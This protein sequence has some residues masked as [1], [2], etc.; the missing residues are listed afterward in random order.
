MADYTRMNAKVRRA[1]PERDA[2]AI[3]RLYMQLKK[4]HAALAPD[5]P[6]YAVEDETWERYARK[7]LEEEEPRFYVAVRSGEVV[8]FLKLFFEEKSW[9]LACEVETLVVDERVRGT[10]VGDAL[11]RRAEEVAR[12]EG[13][14]GMRVNV[15]HLNEEGRRFY[16]RDG[17]RAVAIRYG[18]SL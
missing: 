3:A 10:G 6:R 18:K 16:E 8:G 9:G 4:H 14:L 7:S 12:E 15:L 13:A 2:D 11:M 1:D 17:Y 5:A